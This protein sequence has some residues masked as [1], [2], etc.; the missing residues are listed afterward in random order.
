MSSYGIYLAA[1]GLLTQSYRQDVL[2]NNLANLN[3]TG[4]KPYAPTV[5]QRDPEVTEDNH[6]HELANELLDRLGG[7]VLAGPQRLKFT[8]GALEPTGRPLDAALQDKDL[9][10]AVQ[11]R[12]ANGQPQ[13]RLTRDGRFMVNAKRELVN[14]SGKPVLGPNDRPIRVPADAIV[15]VN[16]RGEIIDQ[17]GDA[18]ARLQVARVADLDQLASAGGNLLRFTGPDNRQAAPEAAVHPGHLEK[19]AVDPI[20]TLMGI[21][22]AAKSAGSNAR[23]ITY[24]DTMLDRAINTFG[25]VA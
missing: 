18:V 13:V 1:S 19:A 17:N 16:G 20:T 4:F 3:T 21:T 10:F 24:L 9:F 11:H 22:S 6:P 2:A 15:S 25:L 5:K 7:G 8:P 23:M 14:T 12:D